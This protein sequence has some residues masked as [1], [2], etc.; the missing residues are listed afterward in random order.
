MKRKKKEGRWKSTHTHIQLV[1]LRFVAFN[2][3][4]FFTLF[5]SGSPLMKYEC[6]IF[7]QHKKSQILKC[8]AA[9]QINNMTNYIFG[10]LTIENGSN[11]FI[12]FDTITTNKTFSIQ[13]ILILLFLFLSLAPAVGSM[14]SGKI[15]I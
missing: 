3:H 2:D 6:D 7:Y 1:N 4:F 8:Q 12:Y 5:R 9:N 14:L 15:C 10:Q 13:L 11:N